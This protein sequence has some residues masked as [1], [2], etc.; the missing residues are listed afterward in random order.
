MSATTRN[1]TRNQHHGQ[2][3]NASSISPERMAKVA[4]VASLRGEEL[5]QAAKDLSAQEALDVVESP[6]VS[7]A[8]R[9]ALV[10]RISDTGLLVR[11]ATG[12]AETFIRRDALERLDIVQQRSPLSRTQ[13]EKLTCCLR[14]GALLAATVTLME[15]ARFDWCAY[16]DETVAGALCH[17]LYNCQ[18]IQEEVVVEDAFAQLAHCRPDLAPS[19]RQCSPERFL[20]VALQP[21]HTRTIS[22]AGIARRDDVA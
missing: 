19:L 11:I 15:S 12:A 9:I 1:A 17:A 6:S 16:C 10:F 8:V 18:G 14:D 5:S 20:P 13:L 22:L 2:H 4:F 21:T 7:R 3:R